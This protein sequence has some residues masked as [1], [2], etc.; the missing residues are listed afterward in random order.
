ML[1]TKKDLRKLIIPLVIEQTLGLTVGMFDAIMV[2]F[3]GES[4]MA[5]VSLVDTIAILLINLF[6]A[7]ASGGA[8]LVG[9]FIGAKDDKDA[10]LAAR[11]LV[12]V[13]LLISV[14][15]TVL[16]MTLNAQILGLFFG[17]VNADVM[18]SARSYFY[19]TTLSYPAVALFN[20]C[21]ALFRGTGNSKTPM[22]NSLI[23]NGI[24]IVGN[25]I[26]I[27][28]FNMGAFGAGLSTTIARYV[29]A[30]TM[31][32]MLRNPKLVISVRS[33]RFWVLD[34]PMIRHILRYGVPNGLENSLFQ[35][36]KII[37][38]G[39]VAT[40]GTAS[41]AANSVINNLGGIEVIPGS[42]MG[43]ALTTV[44]AQCVGAH[45]YEQARKYIKQLMLI[46]YA[47][48]IAFSVLMY[49]A[50]PLLLRVYNLSDETFRLASK[51]M[52]IHSIGTALV[53]TTAFVP[54]SALRAAGDVV[55][56]MVIA[57]V[58]MMVCRVG[59]SYLFVYTTDWAIMS[60]YAGIL[61]DWTFRSVL[62]MKRYL[63]G[64]WRR[65]SENAV[66]R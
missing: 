26:F 41:I 3:A 5:G 1:F 29:A 52:L 53:W 43:I 32:V 58:S 56:P 22:V 20:A 33:Y 37:L 61:I 28:G 10:S 64:K 25:A 27:Y 50:S 51:I 48:M 24:N 18:S 14:A 8:I 21:A 36:G 19:I 9:Q 38:A 30:V 57:I 63:S 46:T 13:S 7:F 16:C 59:F 62:Y 11:Q 34:W 31:L 17:G 42:A 12:N 6:S 54:A 2:S 40:L 60:V 49:A 4:A 65:A 15:I 39:L 35:V 23:M 47:G 66:Y 55:Y 44:V 45:E